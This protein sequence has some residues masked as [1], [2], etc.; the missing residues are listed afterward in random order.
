MLWLV[1]PADSTKFHP[2]FINELNQGR[3]SSTSKKSSDIRRKEILGYAISTLLG[4][5]TSDA[6]FWLSNASLATEMSAIVKAGKHLK[7]FFLL[8]SK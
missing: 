7:I 5:V 6:G 8:H 4:L 3:D 1:A 2:V